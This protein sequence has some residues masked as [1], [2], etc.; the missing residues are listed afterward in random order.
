MISSEVQRTLVKSPPELWAELGD[1]EALARHLGAFGEIRI[2][3]VDPEKAVEWES[4]RASGSVRLKASG[5]GTRVT[6]SASRE[7]NLEAELADAPGAEAAGDASAASGETGAAGPATGAGPPAGPEALPEVVAAAEPAE[8]AAPALLEETPAVVGAA[9]SGEPAT[10]EPAVEAVAGAEPE[11]A[12]E[13]EAAAKPEPAAEP[14]PAAEPEAPAEP[15]RAVDAAAAEPTVAA[16]EREASVESEPPP[17]RRGFF[18]RLFGLGRT[19][20]A[21]SVE[22]PPAAATYEPNAA[23]EAAP[24]GEAP[25][26]PDAPAHGDLAPADPRAQGLELVPEGRSAQAHPSPAEPSQEI[27]AVPATEPAAEEPPAVQE[28]GAQEAEEALAGIRATIAEGG[29]GQARP[30][31]AAAASGSDEDGARAPES[32]DLAAELRAC[33]E[34]AAEEIVAVLTGVLDTLGAAHH[35]PFSR[36]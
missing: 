18:A 32:R 1:Q 3:K 8:A 29:A 28:G 21:A 20:K 10:S 34:A 15:G 31:P 33:E 23:G 5:W 6:L 35:R 14:D 17:R 36:A 11:A 12:T 22:D 27:D 25:L 19:E 16:S 26:A 24:A 9:A 7:V 30:Y 13:P 2:I 4:E